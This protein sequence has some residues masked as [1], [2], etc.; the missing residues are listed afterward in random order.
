MNLHRLTP[1]MS[2][3]VAFEAAARHRSFTRAGQEL[4]LTQSAVSRQVQA[5][6][7]LL[8]VQLFRRTGRKIAPTE[9]GTMYAND[10]AFALNRIRTASSQ[11]LSFGA[12]GGSLNLAVLPTFASRWLLPLLASFYEQHSGVLVHLH[13]RIGKY[14]LA[15]ARMD[16]MINA[17]DGYWPGMLAHR[18]VPEDP[19]LIASPK[20]L[21]RLPIR[22]PADVAR[23]LLLQVTT[24]AQEWRQW[25][26]ANKL[27]T[28]EMRPGPFF[29]LTV[30]LIESAVA[31]IGIGLI[32]RCL[33][34]AELQRGELV[35]PLPPP[36]PNGRAYYFVYPPE[37]STFPPLV[38]FREW[39]LPHAA[40]SET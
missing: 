38:A 28:Q 27:S 7:E 15:E 19:V 18:L 5:L 2:L 30:H 20:L 36:P 25:F 26:L 1:S 39:L 32:S 34:E 11:I 14:D 40:P 17:G 24:R 29:E 12:G 13:S 37:K 10:V 22:E 33:V 9:L 21:E 6:E 8:G 16:A 31:G 4:S 35:L 23:H 3:L